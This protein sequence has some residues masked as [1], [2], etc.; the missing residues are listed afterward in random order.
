MDLQWN[1]L[2]AV[3]NIVCD[4]AEAYSDLHIYHAADDQV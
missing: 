1:C 4:F 2:S 3:C